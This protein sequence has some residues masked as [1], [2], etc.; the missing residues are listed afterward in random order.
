MINISIDVASWYLGLIM[1]AVMTLFI[2]FMVM[3]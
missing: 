2:S 3:K 1:G